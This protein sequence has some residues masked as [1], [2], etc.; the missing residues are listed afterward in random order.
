MEEDRDAALAGDLFGMDSLKAR[1]ATSD[2][3][4]LSAAAASAAQAAS[5]S[6]A[7]SSSSSAIP[8]NAALKAGA[9]I[10][11]AVLDT[12]K[13]VDKFVADLGK[14]LEKLGKSALASKKILKLITG[15]VDETIKLGVLRLDEVGELKRIANVRHND[16]TAKMKKGDKKKPT[17]A[18]AKPVVALARNAFMVSTSAQYDS[19]HQRRSGLRCT[20]TARRA[21]GYGANFSRSSL[22]PAI[23]ACSFNVQH[24]RNSLI[25]DWADDSHGGHAADDDFM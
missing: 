20:R 18:A 12:D 15:V 17:A 14:R 6:A 9:R 24:D 21:N 8:A 2:L 23:L 22:M 16:M 5:P 7:D 1:E 25:G 3:P 10:E 11:E 13:D 4:Q 19:A